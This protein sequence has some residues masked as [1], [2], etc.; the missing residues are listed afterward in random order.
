MSA[1]MIRCIKYYSHKSFTYW[2]SW[3]SKQ[4]RI[5][6]DRGNKSEF[7][8][9]ETF[10]EKDFKLSYKFPRYLW[11]QYRAHSIQESSIIYWHWETAKGKTFINK[12]FAERKVYWGNDVQKKVLQKLIIIEFFMNSNFH[13]RI[14][15]FE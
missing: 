12:L 15:E 9:M 3:H 5:S 2:Y 8:S 4:T 14:S 1:V 6:F 13:S 10:L 7:Y 11:R